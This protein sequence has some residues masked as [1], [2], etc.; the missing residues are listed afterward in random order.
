M[1]NLPTLTAVAGDPSVLRSLSLDALDALLAE[2]TD[3]GVIVGAVKKAITE[4]LT[5]RYEGAISAA[6]AG[7]NKDFGTVRVSDGGY[8]IVVDTPKRVEW[9]QGV[10]GDVRE[11]IQFSGD[12]PSEYI[13]V[14]YEVSETAYGAWPAHIRK[15]FEPARTLKPGARSVKLIRKEA[16]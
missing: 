13:K 16:A 14:K 7:Q 6:Y 10:L 12:D 15:T 2:A 11:R 4:H 8:D 1:K 5:S 9:D 3:Q